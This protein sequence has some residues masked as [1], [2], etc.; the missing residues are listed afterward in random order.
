M[1][2]G[3]DVCFAYCCIME[4]EMI[5]DRIFEELSTTISQTKRERTFLLET[6]LSAEFVQSMGQQSTTLYEKQRS[7]HSMEIHKKGTAML[8]T[9]PLITKK[10]TRTFYV[11]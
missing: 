10:N 4:S 2:I 3:Y 9:H 1:R 8:A 5:Q 11:P 6:R 7:W